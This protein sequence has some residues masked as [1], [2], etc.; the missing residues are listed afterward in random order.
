[1]GWVVVRQDVHGSRFEVASFATR[2]G[3]GGAARAVRVWLPT[4][5]DLLRRA[6]EGGRGGRVSAAPGYTIHATRKLLDR[7]KRPVGAPVE[8]ATAL[9]NWL[10]TALFW[11]PQ[12]ALFVNERT[13]L[14]RCW[15]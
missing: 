8:P 1:V 14:P 6:V 9:G 13:F 3:G 5:P 15:R 11:K 4:P 7:V 10:A 2:G 12:A